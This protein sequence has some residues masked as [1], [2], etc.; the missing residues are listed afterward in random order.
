M[1]GLG[2]DAQ[3]QDVRDK[4]S[5]VTLHVAASRADNDKTFCTTCDV[6]IPQGHQVADFAFNHYQH[7]ETFM[8]MCSKCGESIASA[9]D[10]PLMSTASQIH[11][12]NKP[13]VGKLFYIKNCKNI[14]ARVGTA[15][16]PQKYVRGDS[17]PKT[18]M[19]IDE[20]GSLLCFATAE[21]ET[22]WVK[23]S[24]FFKEAIEGKKKK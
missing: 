18:V 3:L 12:A 19:I 8:I 11:V 20:K 4:G 21:N 6:Q 10:L 14:M 24:Y 7:G 9:L 16:G 17:L 5:Q 15:R 2:V 13:Y 1:A 23:R 22:L